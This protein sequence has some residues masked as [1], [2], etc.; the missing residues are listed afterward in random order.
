MRREQNV[1]LYAVFVRMVPVPVRCRPWIVS[2]SGRSSSRS[3]ISVVC[4][5]GGMWIKAVLVRM[6]RQDSSFVGPCEKARAGAERQA[7]PSA[8]EVIHGRLDCGAIKRS[9]LKTPD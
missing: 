9:G 4:T 2:T 6:L 1:Q 7:H 3:A 5:V 8:D